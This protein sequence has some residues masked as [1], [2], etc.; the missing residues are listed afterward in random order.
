MTLGGLIPSTTYTLT[1]AA[2]WS[3]RKYR[4][5]AIIFR[6]LGEMEGNLETN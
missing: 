3:G 5:R 6:T 4:S 1:V 2:I